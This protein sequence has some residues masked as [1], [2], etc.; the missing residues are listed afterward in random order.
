MSKIDLRTETWIL[1]SATQ[2]QALR[3]NW[4]EYSIENKIESDNWRVCGRNEETHSIL[5]V[6]VSH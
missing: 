5:P 2:Q 1:I 4:I 6:N 3:T